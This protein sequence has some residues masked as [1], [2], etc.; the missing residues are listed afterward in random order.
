MARAAAEDMKVLGD[1]LSPFVIRVLIALRLK[2]VEYEFV[3]VQLTEPKSDILVKS[4]PV[5]KMVPVL[6]HR[7]KP[8]CE[9]AVIVQY[10]D[11]EWSDDGGSSSILPAD[12]FDRA[13]ARFWTVYMDDKL[14]YLIRALIGEKEAAKVT[15]L[16]GQIR[17]VL[18]LLEQAFTECGKGKGFFGGDAVSYL[19]IALGSFLG[20]IMALEKG[21]SVKLLDAEE[22]PPLAGWAERFLAEESVKGLVP[23]ADEHLKNYEV[24]TVRTSATPAA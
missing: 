5:Y 22:L 9:S 3:E 10:I 6:L 7:G 11:E 17:Q 18:G 2:R 4:N 8:I 14:T 23:D 21:K 15:E 24:A 16:A 12:P 20:W 1:P 13:I 19:D